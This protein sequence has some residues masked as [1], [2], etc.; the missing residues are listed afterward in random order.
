MIESKRVAG[1]MLRYTE[2]LYHMDLMYMPISKIKIKRNSIKKSLINIQERLEAELY[3]DEIIDRVQDEI[4]M[5]Q[6]N[7][8]FIDEYLQEI[9]EKKEDEQ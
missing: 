6:I 9:K 3:A 2:P 5:R 8:E 7:I 1:E 4:D